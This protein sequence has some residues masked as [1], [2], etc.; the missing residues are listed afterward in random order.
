MNP[1]L[2]RGRVVAAKGG[3]RVCTGKTCR[4]AGSPQ[5]LQELRSKGVPA[6]ECGCRDR[7]KAAPVVVVDRKTHTHATLTKLLLLLDRSEDAG[8][9]AGAEAGALASGASDDE[10]WRKAFAPPGR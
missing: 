9:E 7:C 8:G 3:V 10:L 5:L 2:A 6:S 1:V 4:K